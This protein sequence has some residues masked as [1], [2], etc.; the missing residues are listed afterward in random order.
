MVYV[1]LSILLVTSSTMAA[2]LQADWRS[3]ADERPAAY[4]NAPPSAAWRQRLAGPRKTQYGDH[5]AGRWGAASHQA[6]L[7]SAPAVLHSSHAAM[8]FLPK[9]YFPCALPA[10]LTWPDA[11]FRY[12]GRLVSCHLQAAEHTRLGVTPHPDSGTSKP[13]APAEPGLIPSNTQD[14]R[15]GSRVTAAADDSGDHAAGPEASEVDGSAAACWP[16]FNA[17][18]LDTSAAASEA[19]LTTAD[20]EAAEEAAQEAADATARSEAPEHTSNTLKDA[21]S[22]AAAAAAGEAANTADRACAGAV[23]AAEHMLKSGQSAAA[24]AAD[25][26]AQVKSMCLVIESISSA[27]SCSVCGT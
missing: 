17:A 22:S 19:G 1:E 4:I 14:A 7:T 5:P 27:Y 21:A 12:S 24:A 23:I 9:A 25:E 3:F 10:A 8:R 6:C 15:S 13:A 16:G 2:V 11:A 26:S 18:Q 20:A